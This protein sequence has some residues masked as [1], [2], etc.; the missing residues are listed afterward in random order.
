MIRLR[1]Q[2]VTLLFLRCHIGQLCILLNR[3]LALVSLQHVFLIDCPRPPL[4]SRVDF[5]NLHLGPRLLPIGLDLA[6]ADDYTLILLRRRG[7]GQ[8]LSAFL[9]TA[10]AMDQFADSGSFHHLRVMVVDAQL[11]I[12][13]LSIEVLGRCI[14]RCVD[15]D[16]LVEHDLLRFRLFLQVADLLLLLQL[17]RASV[18]I[19]LGDEIVASTGSVCVLVVHLCRLRFQLLEVLRKRLFVV[20]ALIGIFLIQYS[21]DLVAELVAGNA[22]DRVRELTVC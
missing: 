6:L 2:I 3:R 7:C 10:P 20:L 12:I 14:G 17:F 5:L 13:S 21:D 9:F 1:L 18:G 11:C 19:P 16:N 4:S 22:C 15:L 8:H